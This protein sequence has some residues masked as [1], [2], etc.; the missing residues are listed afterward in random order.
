MPIMSFSCDVWS[1]N[2]TG[3]VPVVFVG[4][5]AVTQSTGAFSVVTTSDGRSATNGG[6]SAYSTISFDSSE[7]SSEYVTGAVLQQAA[8]QTLVCIKV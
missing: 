5:E 6:G 7:V 2:I 8:L 4:G 1:P 3:T